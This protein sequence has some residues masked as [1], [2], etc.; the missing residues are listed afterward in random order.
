MIVRR[1]DNKKEFKNKFIFSAVI[2]FS[3]HLEFFT[4]AKLGQPW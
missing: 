2:R 3:Q 4:E 1:E